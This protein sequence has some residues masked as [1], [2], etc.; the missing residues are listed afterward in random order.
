MEI[1]CVVA[2]SSLPTRKKRILTTV[3]QHLLPPG[4]G[5]G[6]GCREDWDRDLRLCSPRH[7]ERY[8]HLGACDDAVP[9]YRLIEIVR[10]TGERPRME[11]LLF[12]AA[13]ENRLPE[14]LDRLPALLETLSESQLAV[15]AAALCGI[16]DQIPKDAPADVEN[17]LVRFAAELFA[18]LRNPVKR[19]DIV[20]ALLDDSSRLTGAILLLQH[21]RPRADAPAAAGGTALSIEQFRRLVKPAAE[22]L[23]ESALAGHIWRSREYGALI[24]RWWEWSGDKGAVRQWLL[25]Q[26]RQPE[27]ARAWLRTFLDGSNSSSP[28]ERVLQF[29]EIGQFCDPAVLAASAALASGDGVDRA[30]ARALAQALAPQG[31]AHAI[32]RRTLVVHLEAEAA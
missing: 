3:L 14:V 16:C 13:H 32:A 29:E 19:E 18:R 25:E 1:D 30:A 15:A 17:R 31:T 5:G 23:R 9:A 6:H 24:R 22:K 21:L 28:K 12:K 7:V 20:A 27:H 10:A 4:T 11:Q 2:D 8:F 26:I